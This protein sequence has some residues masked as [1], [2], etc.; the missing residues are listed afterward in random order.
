MP[1]SSRK[2]LSPK[3]AEVEA[4]KERWQSWGFHIQFLHVPVARLGAFR[5]S[6]PPSMT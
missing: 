3:R 5:I 4:R 6:V 2:T 1:E